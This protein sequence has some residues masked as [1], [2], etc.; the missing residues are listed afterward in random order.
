[1][2]TITDDFEWQYEIE[3]SSIKQ[4]VYVICLAEPF[5]IKYRISTSDVLYIGRGNIATR[6]KSHFD[7]SLFSLMMSLAGSNF[8]FYLSDPSDVSGEGYYKQLEYDLLNNF[9]LKIGD[10]QFPILNKN[11][12]WNQDLKLGVG[13]N[14]PLKSAGKRPTWSV[15]PTNKRPIRKLTN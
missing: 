13:W 1:M 3:L 5:T 2:Q 4:G 15:E 7:N 11:A 9:S 6:L 10:G 8:T 14:K 12:G